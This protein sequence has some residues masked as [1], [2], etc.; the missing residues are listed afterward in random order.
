M[1]K[2][3]NTS[4]N[5]IRLLRTIKLLSGHTLDGLS[6][7]DI[8]SALNEKPSAVTRTMATLIAEGFA[9]KL[10]SGRFALS[11]QMLQIAQ[12]TANELANGSSRINELAQRINAGAR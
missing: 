5:G 9:I 8:A 6:N 12:R 10:D 11:V 3:V 2:T 1:E 4:V 7:T